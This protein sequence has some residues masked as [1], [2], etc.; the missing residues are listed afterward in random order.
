MDLGAGIKVLA[1]GSVGGEEGKT[2]KKLLAEGTTLPLPVLMLRGNVAITKR[3]FLKQ[4][5]EAFYISLSGF[6]GL[7]LDYNFAVEGHICRF[8]G[9]GMGY[10]FMHVKIE[11]DGGTDFLGGTWSGQL[12]Y[13]YSGFYLYAKFFF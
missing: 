1:E 11:G 6:E 12:D 9:L 5:F 8:F 4:S 10:N 3:V 7:L 2:K 13:D